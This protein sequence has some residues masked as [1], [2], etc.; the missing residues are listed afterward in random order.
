MGS[1]I[2]VFVAYVTNLCGICEWSVRMVYV[3][4]VCACMCMVHVWLVSMYS[5]Y[6]ACGVCVYGVCGMYV[7][8][9]SMHMY[10]RKCM[11]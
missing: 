11:V 7:C 6:G 9:C 4:C 10:V 1:I 2:C 3:W 8:L 5:V